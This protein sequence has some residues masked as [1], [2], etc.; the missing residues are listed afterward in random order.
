MECS[1][2]GPIGK[3]LDQSSMCIQKNLHAS[4]VCKGCGKWR[5]VFWIGDYSLEGIDE[6]NVKDFL[7]DQ[8]ET[9]VC[10]TDFSE[11][12]SNIVLSKP[13]YRPYMAT[14]EK[15]L[16]LS[17][18]HTIDEKIYKLDKHVKTCHVC[19]EDSDNPI[20][21]NHFPVCSLVWNEFN[22]LYD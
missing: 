9:Y 18:M 7:E 15:N 6:K 21:E 5:A 8:S 17:C 1:Y 12:A 20:V 22:V 19:G 3:E 4:L 10:G 11:E 2:H 13:Y 16:K 14:Y